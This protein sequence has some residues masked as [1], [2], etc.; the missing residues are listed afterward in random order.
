MWGREPLGSQLQPY[1]ELKTESM[2]TE[3]NQSDKEG[4]IRVL[5]RDANIPPTEYDRITSFSKEHAQWIKKIEQEVKKFN[6]EHN[7]SPKRKVELGSWLI[8]LEPNLSGEVQPEPKFTRFEKLIARKIAERIAQWDTL[9]PD[10]KKALAEEIKVIYTIL[11][12]KATSDSFNYEDIARNRDFFEVFLRACSLNDT[13]LPKDPNE[14]LQLKSEYLE[15][16]QEQVRGFEKVLNSL[17]AGQSE[18]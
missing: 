1:I 4:L 7:L 12:I 5:M 14:V 10:A 3:P 18:K 15:V 13:D 9:K 16:L 8:E 11:A 17:L 2:N 6:K